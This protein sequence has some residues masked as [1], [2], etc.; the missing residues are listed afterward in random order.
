MSKV[1]QIVTD[2][3]LEQIEKGTIPWQK[4]WK[5]SFSMPR[6]LKTQK[7]Y[8]GVNVFLLGVQDYDSPYW[9]TFKQ[10]KDL[11]ALAF[12]ADKYQDKVKV[13]S[14]GN[15]SKELCGGTHLDSTG[16]IGL[17]KILSESSIASGVRRIEAVTG[18]F[19]YKKI[20]EQQDLL[21]DISQ[22]LKVPQSELSRKLEKLVKELKGLQKKRSGIA[23]EQLDIKDLLKAVEDISGVKLIAKFIPNIPESSLRSLVD[24][25]KKKQSQCVSLLA[26]DKANKAI[27]VM[28]ITQDLANKDFNANNLI[29]EVAKVMDGSGG[30]RADFARAAGDINKL[31]L[32]F[33]KLREV[34]KNLVTKI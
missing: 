10:A 27:L 31:E 7:Q 25:V 6:N 3:I 15:Y 18:R 34:V 19:A 32:G 4:P 33:G 2:R 30:G 8:R 1:Y 14:I 5:S 16:Q 9:V 28:G 22:Q 24:L 13:M 11:G 26:T 29:K 21:S 12:F 20:S 23:L 17:F